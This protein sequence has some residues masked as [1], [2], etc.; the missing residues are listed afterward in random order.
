MN[1]ETSLFNSLKE[2]DEV[3]SLKEYIE[4]MR[5]CLEEKEKK[6]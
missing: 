2:G 3:L 6:S 1:K 4:A 5:G